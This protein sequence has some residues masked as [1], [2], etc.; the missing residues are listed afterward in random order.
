MYNNNSCGC[1]NC[2][3]RHIGCHSNCEKYLN[4]KRRKDVI[5][6]RRQE[7]KILEMGGFLRR[8]RRY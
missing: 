1:Y 3:E 2:Q 7:F 4:Y 5:K 8:A 6:K